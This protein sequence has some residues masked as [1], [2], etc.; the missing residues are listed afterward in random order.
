MQISLTNWDMK[1]I[2]VVVFLIYLLVTEAMTLRMAHMAKLKKLEGIDENIINYIMIKSIIIVVLA[3]LGILFYMY[4]G[5]RHM[6]GNKTSFSS[7]D[8]DAI[9]DEFKDIMSPKELTKYIAGLNK[10]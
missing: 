3:S 2:V 4:K 9:K 7:K 10:K 5:F 1:E 8:I 6:L